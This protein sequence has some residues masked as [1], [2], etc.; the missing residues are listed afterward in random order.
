MNA[1]I[2]QF[3][4]VADQKTADYYNRSQYKMPVPKHQANII[5][6]KWCRV[7]VV[8][9]GKTTS[10]YGFICLQDGF[11]KTLGA[12]KRGDIHKAASFKAPAKT[13][14]GNIFDPNFP[15][16]LTWAGIVYLK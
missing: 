7:V 5:S 2:E 6:E 4:K 1:A 15:N 12:L 14:R 11:T 9:Q 16:C 10:V 13:A 3:V 8:E